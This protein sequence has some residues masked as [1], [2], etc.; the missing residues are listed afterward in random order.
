M[1]RP[2]LAVAFLSSSPDQFTGTWKGKAQCDRSDGD[3]SI[4]LNI[5]ERRRHYTVEYWIPRFRVRGIATRRA[6]ALFDPN[7]GFLPH[8]TKNGLNLSWSHIGYFE[9]LESEYEGQN[10]GAGRFEFGH[11]FEHFCVFDTLQRV[12]G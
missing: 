6:V 1:F 3:V 8:P 7:T 9:D 5:S 11:K 4:T 2:L 12:K 10:G